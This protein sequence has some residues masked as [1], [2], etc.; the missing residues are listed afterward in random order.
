[1][2]Q[3]D[4]QQLSWQTFDFERLIGPGH[5]ARRI[6]QFLDQLDLDGF[7]AGIKAR[8]GVAGRDATDPKILLALW[9]YALS[10]GVASAR[11]LDRLCQEH[12]AYKWI[13]AGVSV[14]YHTLSDFRAERGGAIDQ[15]LSQILAALLHNRV[16]KLQRIAQDGTRVRAS[17]GAASFRRKKTLLNCLT[18]ACAHIK[19]LDAEAANPDP[20]RSARVRAAKQRAARERQQRLT[21]AQEE[22]QQL[23]AAKA[24]AKNHPQ[25]KKETR[26][27]TTDPQARVMKMPDGGFRPA[28]NLQFATDTETRLIVGV[29]ATNAGT[30][31]NQLEPMLDEVERRTGTT[32]AQALVDGGYMN[33]AGVEQAAARAVTVFAPLRENKTYKI[34][35]YQVQP[36]DSAAIAAYRQRM[37]SPQGKQI[38]KQR[39]ATAE[40]VN[41]DTKTYRGL[42]RLLVRGLPKVLL[43]GLWSALTYNVLRVISKGWL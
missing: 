29:T 19:A 34:D 1:L 32:P 15:L 22:Y 21:R 39:A 17:A 7:Y 16:L 4:R 37:A 24:Q 36:R 5:S 3:A 38:Y 27:S 40:T 31:T 13:R 42:E 25:R 14:N 10:R 28:Y 41:A 33:F 9:L 35:P 18:Q 20:R 8:A 2:R 30:D 6:W 26:V 23:A 12:D 11:E 43:A